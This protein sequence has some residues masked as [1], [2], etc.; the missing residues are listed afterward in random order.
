MVSVRDADQ[1]ELALGTFAPFEKHADRIRA[2]RLVVG[3]AAHNFGF[4]SAEVLLL[5]KLKNALPKTNVRLVKHGLFT[6]A[7]VTVDAAHH[8]PSGGGRTWLQGNIMRRY[9]QSLAMREIMS[10]Q[11]PPALVLRAHHHVAPPPETVRLT[12]KTGRMWSSTLHLVPSYCGVSQYARQVTQSVSSLTIGM[13]SFRLREGA[14]EGWHR[15]T[16]S[17]D[18]RTRESL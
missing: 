7:G 10:R 6:V 13:L 14:V 15:F 4:S 3:T 18:I 1:V 16:E 12:D 2:V 8:G 5:G 9:L 11:D 17:I